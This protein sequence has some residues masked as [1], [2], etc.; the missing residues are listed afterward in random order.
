MCDSRN[1][2]QMFRA[3]HLLKKKQS[4][5]MEEFEHY[6]LE[7]HTKFSKKIPHLRRYTISLVRGGSGKTRPYDG[8][9]EL[10]FENKSEHDNALRSPEWQVAAKDAENFAESIDV[11]YLESHTIIGPENE[12]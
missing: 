2:V 3:I 7:K 12:S 11:L 5:T 10:Y 1:L 9:A 8:V 4:L 6:W